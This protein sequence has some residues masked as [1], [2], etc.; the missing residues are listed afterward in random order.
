V[1]TRV[2]VRGGVLLALLAALLGSPMRIA[3]A[4][5]CAIP[6]PRDALAEADAA[7]VG[8][9]IA[10]PG[11]T[12]S[13]GEVTWTFSVEEALKG[14]LGST[15]DVKSPASGVSCG[16]EVAV[17]ERVGVVLYEERGE[18]HGG[19]CSQIDPDEL[20][21]AAGPL[22]APDGIGPVTF[23]VGG[24]FGEKRLLALDERG[25]TLGYGGG[26]GETL[27]IGVCAGARLAVESVLDGKEAF[28]AV[29]DLRTLTV[30]REVTV[31]PK[32]PS[33]L[34]AVACIDGS[35]RVLAIDGWEGGVA[36]VLLLEGERLEELFRG[37]V[38]ES[39]LQ[40]GVA[41][42]VLPDGEL[43][44]LD[45]LG[46]QEHLGTLPPGISNVALNPD[47][48]MAAGTIY[49]GARPGRPPTEVVMVDLGD[50]TVLRSPLEGWNDGGEVAWLD[51]GRLAYL[52]GGADDSLARVYDSDMNQVASFKDWYAAEVTVVGET[53][54][55]IG[56]GD[57]FVASLPNGPASVLEHLE[58]VTTF[59]FAYVPKGQEVV[60]PPEPTAS[61][62]SASR[63]LTQLPAAETS[64][65]PWAPIALLLAAAIGGVTTILVVR[66]RR[67]S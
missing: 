22:P 34:Y 33:S 47:G 44:S 6:E 52:P 20:L 35:G 11:G 15:V 67:R 25:R 31:V 45:P 57:L 63:E 8:E 53:A 55:G 7:F 19:L 64:G 1:N 37:Q 41:Y 60:P 58:G 18:W 10:A 4:C 23:L 62:A 36:T 26:R 9:L 65:V 12:N 27:A 40:D 38:R 66:A 30:E 24:S 2:I 42:L 14:G 59:S 61:S 17:G 48:S 13:S 3:M 56:W 51:D 54:Y 32:G 21:A 28:L 39:W 46:R 43:V 49:G 50:G 5:S 29:R 16:F